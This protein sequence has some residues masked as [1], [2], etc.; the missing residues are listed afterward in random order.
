MINPNTLDNFRDVVRQWFCTVR[1]DNGNQGTFT[2]TFVKPEISKG[3]YEVPVCIPR[4]FFELPHTEW[5]N[6]VHPLFYNRLATG[7]D[8]PSHFI[9]A[10]QSIHNESN[11]TTSLKKLI[12]FIGHGLLLDRNGDPLIMAAVTYTATRKKVNSGSPLFKSEWRD[13]VVY[14]AQE[15]FTE[16]KYTTLKAFILEGLLY[17]PINIYQTYMAEAPNIDADP[18]ISY[19]VGVKPLPPKKF[20]FTVPHAKLSKDV[21]EELNSVVDKFDP[22]KYIFL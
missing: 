1:R 6:L 13:P 19:Q 22:S 20:I 2:G 14:V 5:K 18:E 16:K 10:W 7:I 17:N 21:N 4:R 11:F 3:V 15:V 12:Y 9:A 8:T